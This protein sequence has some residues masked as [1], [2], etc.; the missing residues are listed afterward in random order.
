MSRLIN[1]LITQGYLKSDALIEAFSHIRREDFVPEELAAEAETN[2][3]LP[4]GYG[5][6]ISQPLTV[7]VMLE[8]LDVKAGQK[9][10]D[11]GSGSGWSSA[12]LGYAVGE[13]GLVV[14]IERIPELYDFGKKNIDKFGFVSLK[15]VKCVLGNGADGYPEEAPYDRIL[16]SASSEEIPEAYKKQLAV[17]GKMVIP[18]Y[19]SLAYIEKR[20][21]DDF[22]IERFPGFVFVPLIENSS[23]I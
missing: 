9:V 12:L 19:N 1:M 2:I 3:P 14:A 15:R 6:T 5:Q 13:E 22:Y 4:I 21:E 18:I 16:V 23:S 17:G 7:A 10:L 20:G 8:L 11:V